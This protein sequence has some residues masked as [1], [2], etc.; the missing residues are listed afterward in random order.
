[1]NN[2]LISLESWQQRSAARPAQLSFQSE[3]YLVSRAG[4]GKEGSFMTRGAD[5]GSTETGKQLF[6]LGD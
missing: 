3:G 5:L 1:M 6:L 4:A 2:D